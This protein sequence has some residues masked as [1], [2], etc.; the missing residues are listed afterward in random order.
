MS[1][2]VK[3]TKSQISNLINEEV[4]KF[5]KIKELEDR[6]NQIVSQLN[7]MYEVDELEEVFGLG[8]KLGQFMGTKWNQQKAE[9][10]FNQT[11]AKTIANTAKQLGTDVNTLKTAL[12]NFMMANGGLA[13]LAGNGKNAN[14]NAQTKAFDRLASKMGGQGAFSMGTAGE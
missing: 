13:I 8:N 14:W 7:E 5:K 12:I 1:K 6:K 3:I 2:T 4:K 10:A 9:Q 11:Y